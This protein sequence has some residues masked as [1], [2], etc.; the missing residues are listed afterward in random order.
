[1]EEQP[2]GRMVYGSSVGSSASMM[3]NIG[4]WEGLVR[5]FIRWIWLFFPLFII[6]PRDTVERALIRT[7]MLE[8]SGS[9]GVG[10]SERTFGNFRSSMISVDLPLVSP[11]VARFEGYNPWFTCLGKGVNELE[12]L[13]V[14]LDTLVSVFPGFSVLQSSNSVTGTILPKL[15][16]PGVLFR[17]LPQF[18]G[19]PL[20]PKVCKSETFWFLVGFSLFK[21]LFGGFSLLTFLIPTSQPPPS[22]QFGPHF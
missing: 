19:I 5:L 22:T 7:L 3:L 4:D 21:S 11:L 12:R 16:N 14:K 6:V 20:S 10:G 18:F 9:I 2:G 15:K 13:I 8:V 17:G 1:M